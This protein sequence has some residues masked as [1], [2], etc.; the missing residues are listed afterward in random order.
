MKEIPGPKRSESETEIPANL[1]KPANAALE[2]IVGSEVGAESSV[3]ALKQQLEDS[4]LK[5]VEGL[6]EL[7]ANQLGTV[8]ADL[9][10]EDAQRLL[11]EI[12]KESD[13]DK[14]SA[15]QVE[16][17]FRYIAITGRVQNGGDKGFLPT[18]TK[19]VQGMDCSLSVWALKQKLQNVKEL[20]FAFGY[21]V[22]H[23]VGIIEIADGR[24]L[25]VDAQNGFVEEV[26]LQEVQDPNTPDTV[27]RIF[28]V[29]E[30]KTLSGHLPKEGEVT[31]TRPEGNDYVPKYLGIQ[32]DGLLHTLGNMHMLLN[33]ESPV[34]QSATAK[35]FREQLGMPDDAMDW[36]HYY[37]PFEDFLQTFKDGKEIF[38]TKFNTKESA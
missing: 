28:E 5:G 16:L 17:I 38:D 8:N 1:L 19:E 20:K 9:L 30:K 18:V 21:P 35:R 4:I 11:K 10:N 32:K 34:F 31:M 3:E 29:K 23:A 26:Q 25:Y 14:L 24:T 22:E 7:L 13:P 37:K 12:E 33:P 15:L 36:R 2:A 6:P 27:Y